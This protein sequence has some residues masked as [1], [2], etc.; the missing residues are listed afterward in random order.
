MFCCCEMAITFFNTVPLKGDLL[1]LE[2]LDEEEF[3][4]DLLLCFLFLFF[5][6][7]NNPYI[8]QLDN[9]VDISVPSSTI[10]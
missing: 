2:E 10:M 6:A 1:L 3:S 7:V 8:K 4:L 5:L 9:E